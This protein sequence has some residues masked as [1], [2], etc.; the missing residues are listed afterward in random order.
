MGQTRVTTG[1]VYNEYDKLIRCCEKWVESITVNMPACD[2][3]QAKARIIQRLVELTNVSF[4]EQILATGRATFPESQEYFSGN[5]IKISIGTGKISLSFRFW[6]INFI[7]FFANWANYLLKIIRSIFVTGKEVGHPITILMDMPGELVGSDAKFVEFCR[8]GHVVPL[9]KATQLVVRSVNQP[10]VQTSNFT[11]TPDPFIYIL[12]HH[13]TFS[14]KLSILGRHLCYLP[15]LLPVLILRPLTI[16]FGKDLAMVPLVSLLDKASILDSVILTTSF[17]AVQPIW[18]KGLLKQKYKLHMLWYSQNFVPKMYTDDE[19]RSDLPPS[20]HMRVDVHWVWTLG[21]KEYL[22]TINQQDEINV[23]GPILWYLPE[24]VEA[25]DKNC[26]KI[27]IFD[28]I[29]IRDRGLSAVWGA[30]QNYYS[31]KTIKQFVS[32]IVLMSE[33]IRLKSGKPVMILLKNKRPP[34]AGH[35]DYSYFEFLDDIAENN[36]NFR[37][38]DHNTNLY[39]LLDE[40]D[41]SISVPYTS[42]AYVT[43]HLLKPAIF[44]DPFA[45]LVPLYEKTDFVKFASGFEELRELTGEIL[46]MKL[47]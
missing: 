16:L 44:Y 18:M 35:H 20:R 42:T 13:T 38:I 3:T 14:Q 40:C 26:I 4:S 23:I 29:P 1:K 31:L 37:L 21:F 17:Y 43:S 12:A 19:E 5:G 10:L 32:D 46:D 25:W 33:T 39:G 9:M 34:K 6:F 28:I 2:K 11:Y 41:L 15:F 27:A 8:E 45:E 22:R 7:Y 47:V 36:S 30:T 24:K